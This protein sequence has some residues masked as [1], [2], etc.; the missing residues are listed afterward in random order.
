MTELRER[1]EA[2]VTV[3]EDPEK[4]GRIKVKC[5][6]IIG[7]PD[8]ELPDFIEPSF[9]W[10][11]FYV[12]DVGEEVE[13]EWVTEDENAEGTRGQASIDNPSIFWTTKRFESIEGEAARPQHDLMTGTNYGKRRGFRTPTGHVLFFDDTPGDEQVTLTWTNEGEVD[14]SLLTMDKTGSVILSNKLGSMVFLNAEAKETSIIDSNSNMLTMTER[15][16][17]VA[18]NNGNTVEMKA[19]GISINVAADAQLEISGNVG[20][21]VGGNVAATVGGDVE[22]EVTG[23]VDA[24]VGGD[25]SADVTGNITASCVNAELNASGT[26]KLHDGADSPL[27]RW[28]E[29][30]PWLDAHVHLTAFGPSGPASGSPTLAVP[31]AAASTVGTLK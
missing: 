9:D 10:G 19:E 17:A 23:N 18:D 6:G 16:I 21:N 27:V 8:T 7:D 11:W 15:G 29:L 5:P 30:Q 22:A 2:I 12:P 25:V 14:R 31:A 4:R 24:T 3:N 20:M 28:L 13:I 26:Y 1:H